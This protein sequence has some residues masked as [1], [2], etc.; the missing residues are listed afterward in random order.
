MLSSIPACFH[1]RKRYRV[2]ETARFDTPGSAHDV[3]LADRKIRAG[4]PG[5]RSGISPGPGGAA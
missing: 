2:E 1:D 4:S 3:A 5:E